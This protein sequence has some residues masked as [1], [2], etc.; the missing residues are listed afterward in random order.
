MVFE[1]FSVS[2]LKA[3]T[4]ITRLNV[5]LSFRLYVL[6]SP[7]SAVIN[8]NTDRAASQSGSRVHLHLEATFLV[9]LL[10]ENFK[11]LFGLIN[12]FYYGV[13]NEILTALSMRTWI[14]VQ[15][16]NATCVEGARSPQD[17]MNLRGGRDGG[18][19]L[20]NLISDI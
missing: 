20:L 15:M 1:F 10:K 8:A 7:F 13:L 2:M 4:V 16:L 18:V 3:F 11:R 17:A 19:G 14:L 5:F 6:N 9:Q 12:S